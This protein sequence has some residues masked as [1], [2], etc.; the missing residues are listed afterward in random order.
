V[1]DR[2]HIGTTS[3]YDKIL[4]ENWTEKKQLYENVGNMG[5]NK[6]I[7]HEFLDSRGV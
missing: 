2:W 6:Y 3:V 1:L 7:L 5:S 4:S